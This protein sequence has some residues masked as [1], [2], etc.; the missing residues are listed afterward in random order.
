MFFLFFL[1]FRLP[2]FYHLLSYTWKLMKNHS[3][4][5]P[6]QW[7]DFLDKI[8]GEQGAAP[9]DGLLND[10]KL[11]KKAAG[12]MA[13]IAATDIDREWDKFESGHIQPGKR[14]IRMRWKP[15]AIGAAAAIAAIW[16]GNSIT[17][18]S[19]TVNNN[20]SVNLPVASPGDTSI[21][22]ITAN[23]QTVHLDTMKQMRE[24]DGTSIS[25]EDASL[26]YGPGNSSNDAVVYNTIII[27]K[28]KMYSLQLSD[29]TKVWL[30][31]ATTLRYPV[32]FRGKSRQVEVEGEAYFDVAK[33]DA[34][35]FSVKTREHMEVKVLG[36]GFNINTY[37][38]N[39]KTTLVSGKVLIHTGED[40]VL[41]KPNQQANYN[42]GDKSLATKQ[43]NVD[44][45]TAWMRN[46]LI[47]DDF[48]LGEIME[49]LGRRYNYD[50]VFKKE[51]LKNIRCGGNL[52]VYQD[53]T[54]V[55]NFLDQVTDVQFTINQNQ[56]VIMVDK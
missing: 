10:G 55:L 21:Q 25:T 11:L 12:E 53:V 9:D 18:Q 20:L 38:D 44:M 31:A 49:M 19:N 32:N 51:E 37:S 52:P 26:V 39:I 30:N 1:T 27:P 17:W 36:T 43:V 47:F 48:N 15:W 54:T 41:L 24:S 7:E 23:G 5:S 22:L 8:S 35:A 16:I 40:S 33:N 29:G 56:K 2:F 34:Q 45:Y 42:V 6:E 28:G 4:P 14:L 13:E 3:S 50:I 46:E